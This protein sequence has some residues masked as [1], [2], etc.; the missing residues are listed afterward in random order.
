MPNTSAGTR[1]IP[2]PIPT[3]PLKTPAN[4]PIESKTR[5]VVVDIMIIRLL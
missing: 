3:N 2:P 5:T 4:R 1:I